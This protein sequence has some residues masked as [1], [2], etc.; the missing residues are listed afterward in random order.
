MAARLERVDVVMPQARPD[1]VVTAPQG[2]SLAA[3]PAQ[4]WLVIGTDSRLTVP[5]GPDRYGS[6]EEAGQGQ[7]ADVL[8]L[9]EP[10]AE[11]LTVL[12]LPR[13]LTIP[14]AGSYLNRL[15]TSYLESPQATIDLLCEGLGVTTT[16]LVTVD[17]AQFATIV[18]SVGGVKVSLTEPMRDAYT[19]LDVEAGTQRLD[20][21][22]AL[23]LV[24]SRHTE[25]LRDGQWQA[26]S[27]AEGAE[28]RTLHTGVVMEAV[29]AAMADQA[30]SPWGAQSLAWTLSGNLGVDPGTGLT[31]LAW[32]ARR[33]TEAGGQGVTV[34][35]VPAPTQGE[36]FVALPT[37]ETFS[38]LAQH[39][40]AP[41]RCTPS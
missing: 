27:T 34:V 23:A 9:I 6:V 29:V 33:A 35:D 32:L 19:G 21:I 4:T 5:R 38:V 28:Q 1:A 3:A 16:H 15:A 41:G 39:G 8:A 30:R 14:T 13:D 24:R 20:G 31:D 18:D 25:V 40:Y 36:G 2:S 11:G 37:E 26:L 12:V 10:T 22:D 17:M 7:R